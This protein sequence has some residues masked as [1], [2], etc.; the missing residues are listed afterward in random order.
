MCEEGTRG[1]AHRFSSVTFAVRP[2]LVMCLALSTP[3]SRVAHR[4]QTHYVGKLG[5]IIWKSDVGHAVKSYSTAVFQSHGSML[6][7][8]GD[9]IIRFFF[10]LFF[11]DPLQS[12]LIL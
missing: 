11:V 9:I 6:C 5:M 10:L 2:D 1:S 4:H 8:V 7:H 3:D 12:A